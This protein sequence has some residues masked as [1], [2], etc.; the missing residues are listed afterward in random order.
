MWL[1]IYHN[2]NAPEYLMVETR[3]RGIELADAHVGEHNPVDSCS[4]ERSSWSSET[5]YI[6][7]RNTS[8]GVRK[9][10]VD[11]LPKAT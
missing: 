8:F 6:T 1:L 4:S 5:S 7:R 2:K 11:F 3:E 9:A 10:T